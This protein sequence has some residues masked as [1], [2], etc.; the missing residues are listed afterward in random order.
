MERVHRFEKESEDD[1]SE[2]FED[3]EVF[4]L[5]DIYDKSKFGPALSAK[6]AE[7]I[8]SAVRTRADVSK[9]N[10]LYKIPENIEALLPP[11]T[12]HAVWNF[13]GANAQ[14][15]DRA[16]QDFQRLLGHAMVPFLT[17]VSK[18]QKFGKKGTSEISVD[19][20]EI[21]KTLSDGLSLLCNV[22]YELSVKRRWFIRPSLP[23]KHLYPLCNADTA[24]TTEL[25]GDNVEK[26]FK[27]LDDLN[28]CTQRRG[29]AFGNRYNSGYRGGRSSKNWQ[30]P[31]GRGGYRGSQSHRGNSRYHRRGRR[32]FQSNPSNDANQGAAKTVNQ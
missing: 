7:S 2:E 21:K 14:T 15:C 22:H 5:A 9:L 13:V 24:I 4:Q 19:S 6:V 29:R 11:H 25:F 32:Q 18:F 23:Y 12:N 31:W 17:L 26:R 20:K 27:E 16:L 1:D 28:R 3:D 8:T 30:A 10:E